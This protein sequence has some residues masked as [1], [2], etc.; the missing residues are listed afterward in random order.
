M[1]DDDHLL[2]LLHFL[3]ITEIRS[4]C[5]MLVRVHTFGKLNEKKFRERFQLSKRATFFSWI[6]TVKLFT[7]AKR[8]LTL[9]D[10]QQEENKKKGNAM[11][12][13]LW[14]WSCWLLLLA[15]I[16]GVERTAFVARIRL[17]TS[18][19]ISVFGGGP[20]AILWFLTVLAHNAYSSW[21]LS[22]TEV[23]F[24]IVRIFLNHWI[25]QSSGYIQTKFRPP[26]PSRLFRVPPG[27]QIS[28]T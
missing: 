6:V 20:I 9:F 18:T 3:D 21:C 7:M 22:E 4:Q 16:R 19:H 15:S 25:V 14:C 28:P 2:L 8:Q 5:V 24:D 12:D 27:R 17:L 13:V 11:Y 23:E 26:S 10:C 1:V